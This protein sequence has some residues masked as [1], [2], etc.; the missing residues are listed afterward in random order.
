MAPWTLPSRG[1]PLSLY[2]YTYI[3]G[4]LFEPFCIRAFV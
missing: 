1:E 3:R 2:M 4:D